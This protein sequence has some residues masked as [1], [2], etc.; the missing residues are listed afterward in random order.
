METLFI[1]HLERLRGVAEQERMK[2]AQRK[3]DYYENKFIDYRDEILSAHFSKP[4]RVVSEF[5]YIN[6]IEYVVNKRA[7]MLKDGVNIEL[8]YNNDIF[9]EW[10]KDVSFINLLKQVE[11]YTELLGMVAVRMFNKGGNVG[12]EMITPNRFY[13]ATDIKSSLEPILF[14]WQRQN[15]TEIVPQEI[16]YFAYDKQYFYI[17][18][19][20][21]NVISSEEHGYNEIPVAF[22]YSRERSDEFY[23]ETD[24]D[25]R[26]AME[27]I[28]IWL[29]SLNHL[30]KYQSY[31]Q[32]IAKGL[33]SK[34]TISTDPSTIINIPYIPEANAFGDF[35]FKTPGAKLL[36]LWET[37]INKLR[38]IG[39]RYEVNMNEFI[40]ETVQR[41]GVAYAWENLQTKESRE[42]RGALWR[43]NIREIIR[44][45]LLVKNKINST[46]IK[47]QGIYID[48]PDIKLVEDPI[49]EINRWLILVNNNVRS[50]LDWVI[51]DNPDINS[52]EEA[53]KIYKENIKINKDYINIIDNLDIGNDK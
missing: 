4:D 1:Q 34:S 13:V 18:D 52:Y 46:I 24:E 22:I 31:A 40:R 7:K 25:L 36:E 29:T 51:A 10:L 30:A 32:P 19:V 47:D 12:Y 20:D 49:Q 53:L 11:R 43:D 45:Y 35:E 26:L 9:Q 41:S 39:A 16:Q 6:I 14:I 44:K 21:G 33:P 17:L 50:I 3:K 8:E 37:L 23:I 28:A 5:E 48:F 27:S 15:Y 42:D 2:R 38:I